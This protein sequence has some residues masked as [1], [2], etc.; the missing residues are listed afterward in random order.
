[1]EKILRVIELETGIV[2]RAYYIARNERKNLVDLFG[3]H[4]PVTKGFTDDAEV[5]G[6]LAAYRKIGITHGTDVK[7]DVINLT[8]I[9]EYPL[10]NIGSH[11]A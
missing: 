9:N 7:I 5:A 3:R 1:M 11:I 4:D 10:P 8:E 6:H 2:V